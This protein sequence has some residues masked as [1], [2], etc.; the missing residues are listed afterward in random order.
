MKNLDLELEN[1]IHNELEKLQRKK[2][3]IENVEISYEHKESGLF[4]SKIKAKTRNKTIN[5]LQESRC[6]STAIRKLFKNLR[7]T[8]NKKTYLR[9][10]RMAF[11]LEEAA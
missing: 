11:N 4:Y 3:F 8:L 2:P 1:L 9:P 6:A 7:R 5:L 10:K